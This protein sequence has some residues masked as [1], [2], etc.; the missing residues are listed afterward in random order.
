METS[1][2]LNSMQ[3]FMLKLFDRPVS[4][5]QEAEI[6]QLLSDYFA[7]E[8]DKEMDQIWEAKGLTQNDLDEALNTHRR[9]PY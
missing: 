5:K 1:T 8:I 4:P 6:K 3:L 9:T 7:A 2:K